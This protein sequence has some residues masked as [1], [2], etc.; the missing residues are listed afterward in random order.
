M[1]ANRVGPPVRGKDFYG[2]EPLIEL[3]WETLRGQSILLVAP[4]R[5][6]KTS[7]MYRLIDDPKNGFV[8]IHADLEP[9]TEA[10]ELITQLAVQL[11]QQNES[12]ATS[13]RYFPKELWDGFKKTFAE[14]DL[15]YVKLKLREHIRGSWQD[16]GEEL[17]KQTA[18]LGKPVLFVLDELPMMLDRMA[19]IPERRPEAV[20]LLRWLRAQRMSPA[21]RDIRFLV[22]GSIGIDRVLA[23]LGES[24]AINDFEQVRLRPFAHRVANEF[25]VEL[26]KNTKFALDESSIAAILEVIGTPVPYFLQI[27]VSE[28]SKAHL[29]EDVAINPDNVRRLYRERVLGVDCKTY[30]DHYYGRLRQYYEADV[31]RSAKR[32]LRELAAAETLPRDAC[33]R[34]CTTDGRINEDAFNQLLTDLENEF[35]VVFDSE[36]DQFRFASKVL[37]DWWLRHYGLATD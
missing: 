29:L 11:A 17:F 27:M 24:S 26:A 37:R 10:A 12:I 20:T 33:F 23:D 8:S 35:Y 31:E 7:V 2:R 22:A 32:L 14:I 1:P 15:H 4:R 36:I 34:I 5:F 3:M 18:A 6:G 13:L 30:F 16:S 28:L 19:R 21:L 25:L 9:F